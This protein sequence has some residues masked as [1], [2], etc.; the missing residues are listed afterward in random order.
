MALRW[1]CCGAP[2]SHARVGARR[3]S[4]RGDIANERPREN[5]SARAL[6][7]SPAPKQPERGEKLDIAAERAT[8][9]RTR[10]PLS[11][12]T[13]TNNLS[14]RQASNV[15]AP[16]PPHARADK[17]WLRRRRPHR[18]SELAQESATR[19]AVSLRRLFRMAPCGD[20]LARACASWRKKRAQSPRG[21]H[22][23]APRTN[24][25]AEQA[26]AYITKG[27]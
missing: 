12:A 19:G 1:K 18:R 10:C 13:P 7:S 5:C 11:T 4:A 8:S 22:A 25:T 3:P 14:A 20:T 17:T 24:T 15:H 27:R 26:A 23:A 2:R 9:P 21:F 16:P 6:P